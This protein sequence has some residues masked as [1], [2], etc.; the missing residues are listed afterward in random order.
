[1]CFIYFSTYYYLGGYTT[2]YRPLPLFDIIIPEAISFLEEHPQYMNKGIYLPGNAVY[3]AVS[4]LVSPY[5]LR[6]DESTVD[7][8]DYY[9]CSLPQILEDGYNYVVQDFY[10][11]YAQQLHDSGYTEISYGVYSLFYQEDYQ[12]ML[13][14]R[15]VIADM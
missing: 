3:F 14:N 9:H 7:L 13:T 1:M 12:E 4:S 8:C 11:E 2:D 6:I 10:V 15:E 5:D